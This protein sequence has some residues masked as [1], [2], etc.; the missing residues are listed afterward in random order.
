MC[1]P[2]LACATRVR[3]SLYLPNAPRVPPTPPMPFNC[4]SLLDAGTHQNPIQRAGGV[5]NVRSPSLP[6][7]SLPSPKIKYLTL[8]G[9]P[10]ICFQKQ[11][12]IFLTC[13]L[14]PLLCPLLFENSIFSV[15]FT[16]SNKKMWGP[17]YGK[18]TVDVES[19]ARPLYPMMLESPDLRW[20]FI[21][22][23]YSILSVQLLLTIAVASIVVTVR[24]I[25]Y[26]F[27]SSP[28]GL[29]LYLMVIILPFIGNEITPHM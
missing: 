26:F 13:A 2:A 23:I 19:G 18:S 16:L 4:F 1:G 24:P 28:A 29:G 8:P 17:A 14:L 21:R 7:S 22:K 15:W 3:T 6:F 20:A 27:V 9:Y 11:P 10:A 12:R 25:S 5:S